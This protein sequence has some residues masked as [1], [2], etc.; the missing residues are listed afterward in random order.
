MRIAKN[1]KQRIHA[2]DMHDKDYGM[3]CTTAITSI[4]S[5]LK[6][7]WI[8][9]Y[10]HSSY[11]KKIC[12]DTQEIIDRIFI[13]YFEPLLEYINHPV[14]AEEREKNIDAA[15]YFKKNLMIR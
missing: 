1:T 2:T 6:N 5:T 9:S 7:F 14:L 3:I 4:S 12:N 8:P 11:I 13:K 15:A 10:L